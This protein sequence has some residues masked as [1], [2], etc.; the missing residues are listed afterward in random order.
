MTS[1]KKPTD[2]GEQW[3][4]NSTKLPVYIMACV[5]WFDSNCGKTVEHF[6]V[7][8]SYGLRR[9]FVGVIFR[10]EH[11]YVPSNERIKTNE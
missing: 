2:V 1:N 6:Y 3:I 9:L 10:K 7:L 8:D 11:T 4:H 5:D